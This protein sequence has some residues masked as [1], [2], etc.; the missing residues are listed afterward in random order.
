[1]GGSIAD[2]RDCAELQLARY[3]DP[4]HPT[5]RAFAAY[6]LPAAART[7]EGD[8][9]GLPKPPITRDVGDHRVARGNKPPRLPSVL[10]H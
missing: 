8:L 4:D 7:V 6:D 10:S 5:P 2:L 1:V 3:L 9:V